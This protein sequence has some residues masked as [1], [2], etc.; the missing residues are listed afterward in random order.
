MRYQK[1][2][3]EMT[4]ASLAEVLPDILSEAK[5]ESPKPDIA[6]DIRTYNEASRYDSV[7]RMDAN[8][9]ERFKKL[10]ESVQTRLESQ[11]PDS[12][13]RQWAK[14]MTGRVNTISKKNTVKSAKT[15]DIEIEPLLIDGKLNPFFQNVIDENVGLIRS[16]ATGKQV[17]FKNMLVSAI[18]KDLNKD[19]LAK[20][21]SKKFNLSKDQA[22]FIARDQVNKLNGSLNQYRQQQIGGKRYIWRTMEDERV[23]PDH[24][25]LDGTTQKWSKKPVTDKR[26]KARNH[27]GGDF[28]CLPGH[29]RVGLNQPINR[30][31]RRFYDGKLAELVSHAGKTIHATMNHPILTQ[32]GF[33]PA[34]QIEVG[35]YLIQTSHQG[36]DGFE[37]NDKEAQIKVEDLF[38]AFVAHSPIEVRGST[39]T[40]FHGDGVIHESIDVVNPNLIL[41]HGLEASL[42]QSIYELALATSDSLPNGRDAYPRPRDFV[43][44]ISQLQSLFTGQSSHSDSVRG[45]SASKLNA[46]LSQSS[47]NGSTGNSMFFSQRQETYSGLVLLNDLLRN[48]HLIPGYLSS[49][50]WDFMT[51]EQLAQSTRVNIQGDGNLFQVHTSRIQFDRIVEQRT[52]CF[53]GHVYNLETDKGWYLAENRVVHNC[54]CYAE[55]II[56][57]VVDKK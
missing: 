43:S 34:H 21:I 35:D 24:A 25:K 51:A 52:L 49:F 39:E 11:F 44:G 32:R 53:S 22:R 46:L 14:A 55:M 23:R 42:I 10:F 45:T 31:Y 19:T 28:Q 2:Y 4:R 41:R 5:D 3:E 30:L 17:Q 15:A 13:L 29:I 38:R 27:P 8:S 56:S 40:D 48:I 33:I 16:I 57:D 37:T 47:A 54:R 20:L 26:T 1:A 12:V 50:D 9:E 7:A 36:V 18:T 6:W